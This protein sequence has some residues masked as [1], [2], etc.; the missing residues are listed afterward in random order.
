MDSEARRGRGKGFE[1]KSSVYLSVI[2][3]AG[4]GNSAR[5]RGRWGDG[6]PS[7]SGW[8]EQGEASAA[9]ASGRTAVCAS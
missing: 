4:Q 8:H 6:W 9:V 5:R 2:E 7:A 3:R 1:A